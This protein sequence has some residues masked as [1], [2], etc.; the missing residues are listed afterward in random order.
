VSSQPQ[1]ERNSPH[2]NH[3]HRQ[4]DHP[5]SPAPPCP[6]ILPAFLCVCVESEVVSLALANAILYCILHLNLPS[7]NSTHTA[8]LS[9]YVAIRMMGLVVGGRDGQT[10]IC[11]DVC[12]SVSEYLSSLCADFLTTMYSKRAIY[13]SPSRRRWYVYVYVYIRT[14]S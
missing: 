7:V 11:S 4:Y 14:Y 1:T 5:H 2:A 8:T 6:C 10:I 13:T 9:K 12:V 3:C